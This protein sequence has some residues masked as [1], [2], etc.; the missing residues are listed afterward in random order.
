[1][2]LQQG[3]LS[4]P[5]LPHGLNDA[6]DH[7]HS[8]YW[9][10]QSPSSHYALFHYPQKT[11]E[12]TSSLLYDH[13]LQETAMQSPSEKHPPID[14]HQPAI[15]EWSLCHVLLFCHGLHDQLTSDFKFLPKTSRNWRQIVLPAYVDLKEDR[16]LTQN[17]NIYYSTNHATYTHSLY[18][19]FPE[20]GGCHLPIDETQP[21]HFHSNIDNEIHFSN[22]FLYSLLQTFFIIIWLLLFLASFKFLLVS[23]CL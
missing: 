19:I 20:I 12:W 17:M 21:P 16:Y 10:I 2:P 6:R 15:F 18:N 3:Q 11:C 7:Q 14:F 4:C 23:V 9:D 5:D 22:M 1:M 13:S 8:E